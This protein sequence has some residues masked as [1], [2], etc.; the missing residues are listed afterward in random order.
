MFLKF[1]MEFLLHQ[2]HLHRRQSSLVMMD[3][4]HHIHQ[5][6]LEVVD[7]LDQLL[8]FQQDYLLFH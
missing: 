8:L 4:Y 3:L 1:D 7:D 5:H 2:H 6:Y